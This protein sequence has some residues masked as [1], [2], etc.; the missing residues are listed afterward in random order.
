[1]CKTTRTFLTLSLLLGAGLGAPTLHAAA[2]HAALDEPYCEIWLEAHANSMTL[3]GLVSSR[4]SLSG[5]YELQVS[6]RS[7][8]GV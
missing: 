7:S 5:S 2:K 4:A 6:Q 3:E 8:G 1:M